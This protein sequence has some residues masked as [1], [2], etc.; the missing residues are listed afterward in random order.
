M[1]I[2]NKKIVKS[3]HVS[4]FPLGSLWKAVQH[5]DYVMTQ[6]G[7]TYLGILEVPAV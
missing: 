1:N 6:L 2:R 5:D 3:S 4:L 7:E